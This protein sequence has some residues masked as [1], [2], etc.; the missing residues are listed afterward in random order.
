MQDDSSIYRD[1]NY[2]QARQRYIKLTI[3]TLSL[4]FSMTC[5]VMAGEKMSDAEIKQKLLGYWK[6]PRHGYEIKSDGIMYMLPRKYATSTNHWDVR[7]GKFYQ[8]GGP[9]GIISLTDKKFVYRIN[10][11]TATLIRSTK[12]EADPE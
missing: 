9:Y 12:E 1:T 6:S 5:L 3:T 2:N 11:G 7:N 4:L 8:D 10:S